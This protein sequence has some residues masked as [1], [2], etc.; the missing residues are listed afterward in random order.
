MRTSRK[1]D[2]WKLKITLEGL[3]YLSQR[4]Q[5]PSVS[6]SVPQCPSVSPRVLL[7]LVLLLL[8]VVV[9]VVVVVVIVVVVVVVV[10][11]VAVSVI[12]VVEVV[13]V[14]VVVIVVVLCST[15]IMGRRKCNWSFFRF[16]SRNTKLSKSFLKP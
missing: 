4:P 5:C 2:F 3:T 7:V 16:I 12:V 8:V 11:V 9:A 14:S 15:I 10:V 6:L 13:A 1:T